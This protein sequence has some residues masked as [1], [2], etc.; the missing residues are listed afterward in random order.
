[1]RL[2]AVSCEMYNALLE[3]WK[4]TYEWWKEHNPEAEQFPADRDRSRYDLPKMFTGVR[5]EDPRW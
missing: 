2:L 5:K 4:G 1:M 3:S